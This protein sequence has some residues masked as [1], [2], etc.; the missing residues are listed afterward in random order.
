MSQNLSKKNL[1]KNQLFV[2]IQVSPF[3]VVC[4]NDAAVRL[5]HEV[6]KSNPI[7]CNATGTTISVRNEAGN[8]P[9]QPSDKTPHKRQTANCSDQRITLF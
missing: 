5:Y 6:A 9:L 2:G 1:T 4:F 3:A 7:F 8:V